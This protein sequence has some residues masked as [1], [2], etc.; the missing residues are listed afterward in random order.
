MRLTN[1]MRAQILDAIMADVPKIDYMA[2]IDAILAVYA[3]DALPVELRVAIERNPDIK[4]YLATGYTG[5]RRVFNC[6]YNVTEEIMTKELQPLHDASYSQY[7]K[8]NAL[9]RELRGVFNAVTTTQKLAKMFPEFEKYIPT[10]TENTTNLPVTKVI[11]DL[12]NAGWPK[13][14]ES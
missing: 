7:T 14:D 1:A 9:E 11:G 5:G 6:H 8:R 12:M 4:N 10:E 2:Q 13:K 3:H